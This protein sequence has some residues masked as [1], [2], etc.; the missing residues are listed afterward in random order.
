M[1]PGRV[2]SMEAPIMTRFTGS[3]I[4]IRKILSRE[5]PSLRQTARVLNAPTAPIE[6]T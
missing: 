2:Y 1:Y 5:D 4:A 6:V 3:D